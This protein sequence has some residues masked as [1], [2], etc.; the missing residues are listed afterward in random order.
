MSR[1]NMATMAPLP[2]TPYFR[3]R[4]IGT[5]FDVSQWISQRALQWRNGQHESCPAQTPMKT[6]AHRIRMD[7]CLHHLGSAVTTPRSAAR[8]IADLTSPSAFTSSTNLPTAHQDVF[9]LRW[10]RERRS[11][12]SAALFRAILLNWESKS[13]SRT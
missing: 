3:P 12:L 10:R 11:C 6:A 1:L 9:A 8:C 7:R 5:R 2:E 13:A 4:L